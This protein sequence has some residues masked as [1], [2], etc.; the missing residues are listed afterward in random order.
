M[1]VDIKERRLRLGKKVLFTS[2]KF[3]IIVA[4]VAMTSSILGTA[5]S[6]V[7]VSFVTA[8]MMF[9]YLG[10]GLQP[11]TASIIIFALFPLIGIF[12]YLDRKSVV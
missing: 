2:L 10:I 3:V 5:N 8:S 11:V 12:N 1:E 7:G 6:F 9:W 4:I